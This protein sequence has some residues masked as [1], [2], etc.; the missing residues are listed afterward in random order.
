M[1]HVPL[2]HPATHLQSQ[3]TLGEGTGTSCQGQ[4]QQELCAK[5]T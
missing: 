2:H 4:L 5:G 3:G 1:W